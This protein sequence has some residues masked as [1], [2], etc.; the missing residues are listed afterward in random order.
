MVVSKIFSGVYT[1]QGPI[2]AL[3]YPFYTNTEH[4]DRKGQINSFTP[5]KTFNIYY[6]QYTYQR[7]EKK[8]K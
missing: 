5:T 4:N 8:K 6:I 7:Y 1:H 3:A 2:L